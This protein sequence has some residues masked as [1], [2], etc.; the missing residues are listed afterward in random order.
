MQSVVG[1]SPRMARI[2]TDFY[3]KI[4]ME[5]LAAFLINIDMFISPDLPVFFYPDGKNGKDHFL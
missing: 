4:F 1:L 3:V 2:Y 5:I